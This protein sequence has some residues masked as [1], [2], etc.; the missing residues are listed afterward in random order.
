MD[1]IIAIALARFPPA[2]MRAS[3][4]RE[5][6]IVWNENK[7]D[8]LIIEE[9]GCC[10]AV[11][12]GRTERR[13]FFEENHVDRVCGIWEEMGSETRNVQRICLHFCE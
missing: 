8:R 7:G 3:E 2:A 6:G 5:Q 12:V 1:A 4:H 10:V 9:R 11:G 13:Y